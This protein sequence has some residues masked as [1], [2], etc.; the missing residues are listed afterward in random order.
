[1]I[2]KNK[3]KPLKKMAVSPIEPNAMLAPVSAHILWIKLCAM[4][5]PPLQV[6]DS[7]R[8]SFTDQKFSKTCP[9]DRPGPLWVSSQFLWI[10]L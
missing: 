9:S 2:S 5:F 4:P 10:R 1:L 8:Q 6:V 7:K 3:T